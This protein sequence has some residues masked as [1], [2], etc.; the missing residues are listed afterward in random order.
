MLVIKLKAKTHKIL[1]LPQEIKIFD[2]SAFDKYHLTKSAL[3]ETTDAV[4]F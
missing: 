3:R 2:K 1:K 4:R